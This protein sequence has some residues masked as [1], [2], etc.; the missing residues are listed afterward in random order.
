MVSPSGPGSISRLSIPK[1][2]RS[3]GVRTAAGVTSIGGMLGDVLIPLRPYVESLAP[4]LAVLTA[5][6]G[7][8]WLFVVRPK[9][10]QGLRAGDFSEDEYRERSRNNPVSFGFLLL[11][12]CTAILFAFSLAD[13]A[14]GLQSDDGEVNRGVLAHVPAVAD[15]QQ[16]LLNLDETVGRIDE[17]TDRIESIA[18]ETNAMVAEIQEKVQENV[19]ISNLTTA[20]EMSAIV[21]LNEATEGTPAR[22]VAVLYFDNT[23]A[24]EELNAFS[25]GLAGMLIS[26]LSNIQTL[27]VLPRDDLE[28]ILAEQEI[29]SG[30]AFDPDTAVSVGKLWGAEFIVTGTYFELFGNLRIDARMIDVET[31]K[32][33]SAEGVTGELK[34]WAKLEKQLVY[35]LAK[36]L[37]ANVLDEASRTGTFDAVKQYSLALAKYDA[38]EWGE[39]R[40]ILDQ[41]LVESPDFAPAGQLLAKVEDASTARN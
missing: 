5:L 29:Q 25:K 40:S 13:A 6:A 41:V 2:W 20:A 32:V 3:T 30:A 16:R 24:Q 21:E 38:G 8:I 23:G 31:G 36:S 1:S 10:K 39:A 28:K 15:L 7:L 11:G 9:L 33:R 14:F 22:R 37:G 17:K 26:D 35:L 19:N 27:E 34:D 18:T 4:V 12:V